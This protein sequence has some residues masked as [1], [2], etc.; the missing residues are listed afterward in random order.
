MPKFSILIP[1]YNRKEYLY[2]TLRTCISQNYPNVEILVID[3]CSDDGT[4]EMVIALSKGDCRVKYIRNADNLGMLQNFEGGLAKCTGDYV[5][6]LGSD[7]GLMPNALFELNEL[8][9]NT[10]AELITW[11]T[12]AYFYEGTKMPTSQLVYPKCLHHAIDTVWLIPEDFYVRNAVEL[13]YVGDKTCPMLYVKSIAKRELIQKVI[14]KSGGKFYSCSTPDGYSA[15]AL[16]CE[17]EKYLYC[18]K[19]FSLHGVSP[20]SAGVNYIKAINP[21]N[22]LSKKFFND[23]AARRL[24]STLASAEYSPLISVMT[25]DFILTAKEV[26]GGERDNA[27]IDI[28]NLLKKSCREL[29]DGLMDE[30]KIEREITILES[31]A[32]HHS[33]NQFFESLLKRSYRNRRKILEGDAISP[34]ARYINMSNRNIN[35]V[36][37]ASIYVDNVLSGRESISFRSPYFIFNSLRY[38]ILGKLKTQKNLYSI[39]YASQFKEKMI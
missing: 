27:S 9:L 14:N 34:S 31:I 11:P 24:H 29:C 19:P 38:L 7:D 1:S 36:F 35:N 37:D 12:P 8:I 18:K 25:A 26:V 39:K 5:I 3:D 33:L 4:E 15:F 13:A 10:N 20:S 16:L 23:S 17:V 32:A 28:K 30:S 21:K 6:V 22:D 2:Q